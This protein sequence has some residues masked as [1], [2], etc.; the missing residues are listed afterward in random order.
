MP[1]PRGES[2]AGHLPEVRQAARG[3]GR[4]L[5]QLREGVDWDNGGRLDPC[6]GTRAGGGLGSGVGGYIGPDGRGGQG[7]SGIGRAGGGFGSGTG[8]APRAADSGGILSGG[9]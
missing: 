8:G 6:G 9:G 5:R 4:P 3:W 7:G 2:F 1:V